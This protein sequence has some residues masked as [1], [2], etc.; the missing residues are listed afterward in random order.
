MA[1]LPNIGDE[2]GAIAAELEQQIVDPTITRIK[3]LAWS[4]DCEL[5]A[6]GVDSADK[7][8]RNIRAIEAAW[9]YRGAEVRL[10]G[11]VGIPVDGRY[12]PYRVIERPLRSRGFRY[13]L[14]E[15][16]DSGE[17]GLPRMVERLY[18]E[19]EDEHFDSEGGSAIIV[20]LPEHI[21]VLDLP[22]SS[23]ELRIRRFVYD[24]P[25]DAA[26]IDELA[27]QARTSD[28]ALL[29]FSQ[30]YLEVD[31]EQQ[32]HDSEILKDAIA[33]LRNRAELEQYA[34]YHVSFKGD[35]IVVDGEDGVPAH[36]NKV[37][38]GVAHIRD[39]TLRP[40]DITV[41]DISHG[42]HTLVP[43]LDIV[44][45]D[46]RGDERDKQ[47]LIPCTSFL[48]IRSVRYPE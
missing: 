17:Q 4:L 21:E 28:Q 24:K 33:Y 20:A 45:F 14:T 43:F 10:S 26:Y 1:E 42:K 37:H 41:I 9:E 8:Q 3:D 16:N 47:L 44:F 5:L 29:E 36:M 11:R 38:T 13:L 40:A 46:K 12:E 6:E 25:N 48:K 15:F 7:K 27:Y 39:I 2:F 18:Y 35:L 34:N 22:E 23:D 32:P 31:I 30:Y 19:F